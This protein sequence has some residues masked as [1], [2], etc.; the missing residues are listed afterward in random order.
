MT[1]DVVGFAPQHRWDRNAF[2]A[3]ILLGWLGVILGFGGDMAHHFASHEAPYPLIVHIHA[4]AFVGWLVLF[5]VQILLIRNRSYDIHKLLGIGLAVLA[6]SMCILGPMAEI[7]V[8]T[9][10]YG[11]PDSDPAFLAISFTEMTA[12]AGLVGTAL[13]FRGTSSAHKRL[14]LLATLY[15]TSAG[16]ARFEGGLLHPLVG[17]GM[18]GFWVSLYFGSNLVILLLGVYD[19]ITRRRLHPAYLLGLVWVLANE[20]L[21]TWLY[22]QPDWLTVCKHLI[23]H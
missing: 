8:Q 20:G 7:M 19:L 12:F 11:T 3:L 14:I 15:I 21:S 4:A 22:F 1:N 23:G 6:V 5:T 17:G 13:L 18:W 10:I 9:H 16:F 2:L